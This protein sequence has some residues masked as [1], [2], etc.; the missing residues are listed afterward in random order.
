MRKPSWLGIVI[1]TIGRARGQRRRRLSL[2]EI[3]SELDE[4]PDP[5]R[6]VDGFHVQV[7]TERNPFWLHRSGDHYAVTDT[8]PLEPPFVTESEARLAQTWFIQVM[9]D[10]ATL[11]EPVYTRAPRRGRA[12]VPLTS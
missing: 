12:S 2:P 6:P 3:L 9:P 1:T 5:A 10:V 8:R 11:C 4:R 7:G